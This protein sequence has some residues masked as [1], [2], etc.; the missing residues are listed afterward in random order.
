MFYVLVLEI[1]PKSTDGDPNS[2][3]AEGFP[4]T[5]EVVAR[6]RDVLRDVTRRDEV[7]GWRV[8]DVQTLENVLSAPRMR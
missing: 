8:T 6:L 5:R 4:G 3:V 1:E 7:I 2:V